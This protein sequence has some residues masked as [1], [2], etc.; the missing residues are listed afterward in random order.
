[1]YLEPWVTSFNSPC[2]FS[3]AHAFSRLTLSGL[4]F[5]CP[6]DAL[7]CLHAGCMPLYIIHLCFHRVLV[8]HALP[9]FSILQTSPQLMK[10]M[11]KAQSH[12][13]G[14]SITWKLLQILKTFWFHGTHIVPYFLTHSFF[15]SLHFCSSLS[16][17][18]VPFLRFT[19]GAPKSHWIIRISSETLSLFVAELLI[20]RGPIFWCCHL[21]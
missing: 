4:L 19:C 14:L 13:L 11:P 5:I 12:P 3:N 18:G 20:R 2:A 15:P 1:M 10:K 8:I 17:A 9:F 16:R 6:S 7:H 21:V